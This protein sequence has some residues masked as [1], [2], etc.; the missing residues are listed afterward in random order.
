MMALATK[1][2]TRYGVMPCTEDVDVVRHPMPTAPLA[3]CPTALSPLYTSVQMS[4]ACKK[5]QT[6]GGLATCSIL[7]WMCTSCAQAAGVPL[8]AAGC[9]A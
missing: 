2:T 3:N 4:Y 1:T 7:S 6:D 5:L 9:C 8:S